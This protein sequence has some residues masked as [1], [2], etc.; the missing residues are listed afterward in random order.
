MACG[1]NLPSRI[2]QL[3]GMSGPVTDILETCVHDLFH[4]SRPCGR[5]SL[6]QLTICFAA[7]LVV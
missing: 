1:L 3:F 7:L 4:F 6:M 5:N 2:L